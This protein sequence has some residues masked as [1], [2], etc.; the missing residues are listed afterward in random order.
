MMTLFEFV[1]AI[2]ANNALKTPC[3][4]RRH[5]A[6]VSSFVGAGKLNTCSM[7][8]ENLQNVSI[9]FQCYLQANVTKSFYLIQFLSF[10]RYDKLVLL[11]ATNKFVLV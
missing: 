2:I 10:Y 3:A 8:V 4:C 6:P 11:E 1:V 5:N 7:Q 9:G